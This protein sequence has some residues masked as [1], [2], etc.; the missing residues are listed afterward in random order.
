MKYIVFGNA[1]VWLLDMISGG[2]AS[3]WLSF[4]P[5]A[6]L[7]GQVWR[8]VTFVF[9]PLF[10]DLLYLALSLLLYYF[11]GN[12]L[13]RAW[14][15]TRFTVYYLLG[16]V[17]TAL[18]GLAL[19]FTPFRWYVGIVNMHYVNLSLFLAFASL[20]PDMQFRIYFIIPIRGKWLAL[21][22][23]AMVVI[24]IVRF[25]LAGQYVLAAVPVISLLNWLLFFWED[26]VHGGQKAR[27]RVQRKVTQKPVD[28]RA[29][30]KQVQ[31][32]KGYLHKCCVCGITD[33]DDRNMEFRYCSRCEGYHCYCADHINNHTHVE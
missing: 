17:L 7:Q 23:A 30:Q 24:D 13:E 14:G 27:I 5:G 16:V 32:Q 22:Y 29:A 15:S 28:L 33:A 31:E 4:V 25:A 8:L 11:L 2:L 6:I 20:Y 26:L 21:V 9:V 18:C 1:I 19:W 12:Q 10:S 3:Y